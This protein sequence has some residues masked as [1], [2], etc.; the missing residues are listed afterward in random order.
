MLEHVRAL[1]A[2]LV[3]DVLAEA[4]DPR[5]VGFLG[6]VLRTDFLVVHVK[7]AVVLVIISEN[8][9]TV[10]ALVHVLLREPLGAQVQD[11]QRVDG[12]ELV[13]VDE[14][15][16]RQD[17]LDVLE[18][19]YIHDIGVDHFDWPRYLPIAGVPVVLPDL[20][21]EIVLRKYAG[22][23]VNLGRQEQFQDVEQILLV[24]TCHRLPDLFV[25]NKLYKLTTYKFRLH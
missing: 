12:A 18:A 16:R 14:G 11:S 10:D 21:R 13:E 2:A 4:V 1:F 15:Q 3:G 5:P 7:R 20:R 22:V 17:G 23:I 9:V 19:V 6:R 24:R 25:N 8:R